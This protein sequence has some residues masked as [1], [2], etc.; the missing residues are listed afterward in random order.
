[1]CKD[2]YVSL[3]VCMPADPDSAESDELKIELILRR[4]TK[5]LD[6]LTVAPPVRLTV[7]SLCSCPQL[8][9]IYLD[10]LLYNF[11]RL[12]VTLTLIYVR[13]FNPFVPLNVNFLWCSPGEACL[14]SIASFTLPSWT[15]LSC[16]TW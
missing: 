2:T 16:P 5:V 11:K 14:Q 13:T 15:S 6:N 7:Y 10:D 1:M 3:L 4:A 8:L 12:Y 9:W